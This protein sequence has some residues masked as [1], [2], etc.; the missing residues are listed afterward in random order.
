MPYIDESKGKSINCDDW[1]LKNWSFEEL[2][3]A[4]GDHI[5]RLPNDEKEGTANYAI[6]RIVASGLKPHNGWRYIWLNR[7]YGT[8]LSAAAEFYRRVVSKYEDDCIKKNGDIP[9]YEND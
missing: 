2:V 7:A 1:S 6:S 3:E 8:F 5:S 4:I 9:E